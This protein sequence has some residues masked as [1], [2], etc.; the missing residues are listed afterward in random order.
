MLKVTKAQFDAFLI[1][2]AAGF[3]VDVCQISEPPTVTYNDFTLGDWPDSIIAKH[4][5]KGYS[6]GEVDYFIFYQ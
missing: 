5:A 6:V 1:D 3:T 2:Y 4:R